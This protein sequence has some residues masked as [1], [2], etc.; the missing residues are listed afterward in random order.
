MAQYCEK[1]NARVVIPAKYCPECGE[2]LKETHESAARAYYSREAQSTVQSSSGGIRFNFSK[3]LAF[4]LA[5]VMLATFFFPWMSA[6]A[7]LNEMKLLTNR[8]VNIFELPSFIS[9]CIDKALKLAGPGSELTQ[10]GEHLVWILNGLLLLLTGLFFII[11]V[12]FVLFGVIGLFSAGKLRYYF[13]RVGG[14]LYFIALLL[15][16]GLV[17]IGN[18]ALASISEKSTSEGVIK[19]YLSVAPT[20]YVYA[21]AVLALIFRVLGVRALRRL[22]AESCLNRGKYDIARREI[23]LLKSKK[24]MARLPKAYL[25]GSASKE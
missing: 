1:C 15:F 5:L 17:F 14:T 16:I 22:N 3:P 18:A 6:N 19:L 24:L 23:G 9:G 8:G 7:T 20:V 2:I 13:A 12:H 4:I 10:E 25:G 21:A 11:A